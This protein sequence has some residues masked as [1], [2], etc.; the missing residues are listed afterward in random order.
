MSGNVLGRVFFDS[1]VLIYTDDS[2]SPEK[3]R[4]ARELVDHHLR[5]NSGFLSVQVLQE[6]FV[7]ATRK[8][9]VDAAVAREKI[10]ILGTMHVVTPDTRDVLAAIDLHRLHRFSFW[11]SMIFR[12][13]QESG[14]GVLLS[15]DLQHGRIIDGIEIVNPFLD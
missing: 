5:R 6:Y 8:H 10:E 2:T 1:N 9:G 13:V 11:D 14:C 15:E 3:Q 4:K 12:A 7:N